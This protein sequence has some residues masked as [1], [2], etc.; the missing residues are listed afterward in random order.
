MFTRFHFVN[1]YSDIRSTTHPPIANT[2]DGSST[3][4]IIGIVMAVVALVILS[5]VMVFIVRKLPVRNSQNPIP[6]HQYPLLAL[7]QQEGIDMTSNI[8]YGVIPPQLSAHCGNVISM[9]TNLASGITGPSTPS[10]GEIEDR[11]HS[12]DNGDGD[13]E[14]S[15]IPPTVS[16]RP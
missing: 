2:A 6:S 5:P 14:Y 7:D 16:G 4:V 11:V 13:D 12:E 8:A 1:A 9:T 10:K 3:G 15:Y